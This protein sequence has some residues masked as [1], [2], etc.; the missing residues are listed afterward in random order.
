MCRQIAFRRL[1]G[2]GTCALAAASK[3]KNPMIDNHPTL[4]CM[5]LSSHC[6]GRSP[7]R[8]GAGITRTCTDPQSAGSKP[9]DHRPCRYPRIRSPLR[10]LRRRNAG[11]PGSAR[12]AGGRE[13]WRGRW[14]RPRRPS[15]PSPTATS[16]RISEPSFSTTSTAASKPSSVGSAAEATCRSSGRMPER[17]LLAGIAAEPVGDLR[18][19]P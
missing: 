15:C 11:A 19:A 12:G 9:R 16:S 6:S 14:A 1:D 8:L 10:R 18:A 5:R 13:H 4:F 2:D 17:H 7:C 3:P